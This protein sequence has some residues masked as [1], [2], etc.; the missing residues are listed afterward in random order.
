MSIPTIAAARI[1]AG[2]KRGLDGVSYKLV[3]EK[4]PYSALSRTY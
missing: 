1:Y 3:M 4:L 2:Q